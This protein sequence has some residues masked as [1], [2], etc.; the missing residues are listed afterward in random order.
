VPLD[1]RK[2]QHLLGLVARSFQGR[3]R[4]VVAVRLSGGHYSYIP[5]QVIMRPQR[6]IDPQLYDVAGRPPEQAADTLMIAPAGSDFSG[7]VY[8]ADT[9]DPGAVA[10]AP[11]YELIEVLPVGIVPGGTHLRILLRRLR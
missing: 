11:K 9:T 6:I 10:T 7:V 8:I 2:I 5:L 3:E 4:T 1:P